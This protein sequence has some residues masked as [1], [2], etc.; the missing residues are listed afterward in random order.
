MITVVLVD[1]P[2]AFRDFLLPYSYPFSDAQMILAIPLA[3]IHH[4]VVFICG[5]LVVSKANSIEFP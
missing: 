4:F 5:D 2:S 1:S 3:E